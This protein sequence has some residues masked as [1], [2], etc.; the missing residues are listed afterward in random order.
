MAMPQVAT[1]TVRHESIMQHMIANPTAKL[2]DVARAFR[3]SAPWLSCIIHSHAF[4]SKLRE[5]QD[6]IFGNLTA[7]IGE[8][9]EA[10]AHVA[11]DNI[12]ENLAT[13]TSLEANLE[14]AKSVL[15]NLGYAPRSA[16]TPAPAAQ[17][18]IINVDKG[19]LADARA[20]LSGQAPAQ[21]QAQPQLHEA[22][23]I[24]AQSQ[25]CLVGAAI[26][27]AAPVSP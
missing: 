2:G 4:K 14:V 22:I 25:K 23:A 1:L 27:N 10:I 18:S 7:T 16:A 15:H 26:A 12:G 21:P 11:L 9:L 3:V 5:Q 8:K 24:D 19:T 6:V 13:N 17:I 20:I